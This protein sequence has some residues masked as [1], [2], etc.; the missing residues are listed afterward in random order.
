MLEGPE[1]GQEMFHERL[2]GRG[3]THIFDPMMLSC[4]E[5]L[6]CK[7]QALET[8]PFEIQPLETPR[9][10]IRVGWRD[11]LPLGS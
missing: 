8:P 9:Q 5:N 7:I 6:A 10:G 3:T 4:C 2:Q 1:I 11:T